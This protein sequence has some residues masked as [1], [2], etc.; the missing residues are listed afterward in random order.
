MNIRRFYSCAML[1]CLLMGGTPLLTGCADSEHMNEIVNNKPS[2]G[3][4]P[5]SDEVTEKLMKVPGVSDVTM[6]VSTKD[7]TIRGYYFFVNQPVDHKNPAKGTFAQRCYLQ[8]SGYDKPVVL[9]TEGYNMPGN[10]DSVE[11]GDLTEYLQA[12][13]LLVEYRYFGKSLPEDFYDTNFTYLYSDQAAADLHAV[14]KLMQQY[15]FP[16]SNK[17]VSTGISKG[18]IN[19]TL[20][21]YY[22]DKNGWDDIDL[23]VPF[24]APFITDSAGI[25][26]GE[27]VGE[28]LI[29]TCGSGYP[30]TSVEDSAY[31]RLRAIPAAICTNQTL[32]DAILREFHHQQEGYY[33]E[34]LS[35]F[36]DKDLEKT[37]TAGVLH[38]FYDNLFGHFST[39]SFDSWAKFV[40]DLDKAIAPDASEDD[41]DEMVAFVYLCDRTLA[42]VIKAFEKQSGETRSPYD[43]RTIPEFRRAVP[44]MPYYLQAYR[45]LGSYKLDFSLVDG[46]WLTPQLAQKV[47]YLR[48]NE[49][50]Y[51]MRYPNQYD[52]GRLMTDVH[53]WAKTVSTKPLVFIYS[54][55]DPWTGAGISDDAADSSRKVWKIINKIGTH[56]NQF[57]DKTICDA[58]ASQAIKDAID[59]VL[60]LKK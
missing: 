30:E 2:G 28:Y 48:S 12:N 32:R 38:T 49:Y 5:Y 53:N 24:C 9:E 7:S 51:G 1:L 43:D 6:H 4:E 20:Y 27:K 18:G 59:S 31:Q 54:R 16:R 39:F 42:D 44:S 26:P 15:M 37:A 52:G 56:D 33:S 25:C 11:V 8:L 23:F 10:I 58:E 34:I 41:I 35:Y 55:N 46:T 19:T 22:S 29:S 40:P 47:S 3:E 21:A 17:W 50:M 36:G 13:Y 57:L 60:G 45:E 14:V